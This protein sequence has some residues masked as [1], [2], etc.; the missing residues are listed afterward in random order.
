VLWRSVMGGYF[1]EVGYNALLYKNPGFAEELE[2]R[3]VVHARGTDLAAHSLPCFRTGPMG[4]VPYVC[5]DVCDDRSRRPLIGEIVV[6][7]TPHPE[8]AER[9]V[10]MLLASVGYEDG[11]VAIMRS[12]TPLRT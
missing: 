8:L 6:G 5:I 1:G 11:E 4:L 2:W 3:I 7:P 12:E 9:S 10:R